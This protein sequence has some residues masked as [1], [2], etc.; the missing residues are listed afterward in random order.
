MNPHIKQL[1]ESAPFTTIS[2]EGRLF[3]QQDVARF[4][5]ALVRECAD[6]VDD[7]FS[8]FY[9]RT[10]ADKIKEHFGVE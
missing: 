10:A 5:Q 6:Q 1:L 8:D 9:N 4:A 7:Y 3:T 2:T